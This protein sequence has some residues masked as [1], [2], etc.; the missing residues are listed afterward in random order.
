[1]TI[2]YINEQGVPTMKFEVFI[3]RLLP[4]LLVGSLETALAA[5]QRQPSSEFLNEMNVGLR[6]DW[7]F[8]LMDG[9]RNNLE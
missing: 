4:I 1:M 8:K 7:T 5:Q 2:P 9:E 3:C 6:N